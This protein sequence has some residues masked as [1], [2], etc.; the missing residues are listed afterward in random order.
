MSKRLRAFSIAEILTGLAVIALITGAMIM[1]SGAS[2]QNIRREAERIAAYINHLIETADKQRN[3]FSIGF[4]NN[5]FRINW[6]YKPKRIGDYITPLLGGSSFL[7]QINPKYRLR[8]NR[9]P[10]YYSIKNN[11]F[12]AGGTITVEE[13][14]NKNVYYIIIATI[15]GR[16][17]TSPNPPSNWGNRNHQDNND[18]I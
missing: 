4:L 17:R 9:D 10:F 2:R 5:T 11:N 6:T 16:V 13:I 18:T 7:F 15:G 12:A 1:K 8:S 14:A 3:P